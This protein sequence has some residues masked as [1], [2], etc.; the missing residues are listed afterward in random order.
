M[1]S[2][3]LAESR[4]GGQA[5]P[6]LA[7]EYAGG[8]SVSEV[9][10]LSA[11][12]GSRASESAHSR[13]QEVRQYWRSMHRVVLNEGSLSL[14]ATLTLLCLISFK[15]CATCTCLLGMEGAIAG[16]VGRRFAAVQY[17][18]LLW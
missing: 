4:R 2:S 1:R 5:W 9:T 11:Y 16:D 15:Y 7:R 14:V 6:P 3:A 17:S 18:V 12:N 8:V 13:M 10:S